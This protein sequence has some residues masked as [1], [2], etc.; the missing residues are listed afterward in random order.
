MTTPA[1]PTIE[2]M[3]KWMDGCGGTE[4]FPMFGVIRSVLLSHAE[5][6]Q[7]KKDAVDYMTYEEYIH[8]EIPEKEAADA[9]AHYERP[10]S[11]RKHCYE[12][13]PCPMQARAE[14]AEALL[15]MSDAE[16]EM[17]KIRESQLQEAFNKAEVALAEQAPL[18]EAAMGEI[19]DCA[20][21]PGHPQYTRDAEDDV[22]LAALALRASRQQTAAR[23][24]KDG[25]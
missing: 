1:A 2:E 24:G 16:V 21:R 8:S 17:A 7:L 14:K 11:R 6:A 19:M 4:D 9:K 25:R 20:D 15:K 10:N 23:E 13:W 12:V 3:V 5:V 22:V 18:V